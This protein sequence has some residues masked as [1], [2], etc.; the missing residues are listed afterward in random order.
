VRANGDVAL[1]LFHCVSSYP[2]APADSNL[3]AIETM[4]RAFGVPVGWSDHTPG[5]TMPIAAVAAG[6]TLVEKHVTLDRTRRGP[7][8]AASLEPDQLAAMVRAIREVEAALGTGRK[9]PVDA[10]RD[11]A[12]VARRSVHWATSLEPGAE[13]READLAILR[14]GTGLRPSLLSSLVGRRTARAVRAGA[15]VRPDDLEPSG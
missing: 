9:V 10:E 8:H 3:R 5:I 15:A 7:D 1:A 12:A 6:A 11:V 14:P 4:R 13:L 2:A